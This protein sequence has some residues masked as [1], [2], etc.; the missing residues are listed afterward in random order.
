MAN[1]RPRISESG[2]AS[3]ANFAPPTSTRRPSISGTAASMSCATANVSPKELS[4]SISSAAKAIVPAP[5][6]CRPIWNAPSGSYG[7]TM[8]TSSRASSSSNSAV[9]AAR[10]SGS[11]TPCS[12]WN[13]IVPLTPAPWPPKDCSRMSKPWRL[14]TAGSVNSS[15]KLVPTAPETPPTTTRTSTQAPATTHRLR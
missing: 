15:E 12:A 6:P 5:G 4:W 8:V 2:A 1:A 13:T 11:S 9:I 7:L 14:S 10:T 3:S